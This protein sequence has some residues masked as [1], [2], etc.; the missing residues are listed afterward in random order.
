[1]AGSLRGMHLVF[2]LPS[3]GGKGKETGVQKMQIQRKHSCKY[4]TADSLG[5][6]REAMG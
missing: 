5:F 6:G 1:M 2:Y 4:L 3:G